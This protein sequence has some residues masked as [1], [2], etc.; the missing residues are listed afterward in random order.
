[1]KKQVKAEKPVAMLVRFYRRE[2]KFLAKRA[3]ITNMS[4]ASYIRLLVNE[5]E[6]RGESLKIQ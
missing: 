1:M 3:R 2:R 6:M 5:D 4:R